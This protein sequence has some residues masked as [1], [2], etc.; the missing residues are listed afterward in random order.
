MVT[1]NQEIGLG[2]YVIIPVPDN[3]QELVYG[4]GWMGQGTPLLK[5]VGAL[6]GDFVSV[7]DDGLYINEQYFGPVQS[8]DREGR[9]IPPFRGSYVIPSGHFLPLSFYERSFDGRYFGPVSINTIQ[10]R[11]IP[12]FTLEGGGTR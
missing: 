7:T 8:T 11:V 9:P 3:Y 12:L 1:A 5:K 6:A 10:H 2:D 4:R